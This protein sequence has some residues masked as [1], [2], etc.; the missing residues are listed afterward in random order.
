[1]NE[2]EL[3][4]DIAD[5]QTRVARLEAQMNMILSSTSPVETKSENPRQ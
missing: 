2:Y 4:K 3:G 1:M 5:L